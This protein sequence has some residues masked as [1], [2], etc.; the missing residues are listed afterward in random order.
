[1]KDRLGRRRQVVVLDVGNHQR[2][3]A[4]QQFAVDEGVV[5]RNAGARSMFRRFTRSCPRSRPRSRASDS[6][7]GGRSQPDGKNFS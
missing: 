4:L 3:T 6:Q 2:S 1:M 5:L 7:Q